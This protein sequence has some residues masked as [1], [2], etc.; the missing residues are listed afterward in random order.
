MKSKKI[1][2]MQLPENVENISVACSAARESARV[3]G[4]SPKDVQTFCL[5]VEEALTN[6]IEMGFG[7]ADDEVDITFYTITSGIGVKIRSFCL[8]LEPEKLPQYNSQRV[9]KYNDTTGLSYHLVKNMSDNFRVYVGEDGARELYFEKY[10]PEQKVQ[11]TGARKK[12]LRVN[13]EHIKRFAVPED[14]ENISRLVLRSH[15]AVLF[16]ESIYYPDMVRE[17]LAEKKMVSVVSEAE[18]GELIAH[19]ALLKD[20]SGDRVEEL[21]YVVSDKNYK[22]RDAAKLP[23]I[24]VED[25]KCR[26]VYA[27]NS[28][29]VTNHVY[30]QKGC[31]ADG[32][33]ENALYLALNTASRHTQNE[34]SESHR[35]GTLGF[36]RYLGEMSPAP[37]FLPPRHREMILDIYANMAIEPPVAEGTAG[38]GSMGG[39]SHIVTDVGFTEGW[40][41]IV[42]KE[43]GPDT[44]SHLKSEVYKAVVQGIPSIQLGLPLSNSMTLEMCSEFESMGFF[45]A[46]VSSG[47]NC[48]ENL[49][50][51]YLNGV[52]P[53]FESVHTF[54]DFAKK[55]KE[56]VAGCWEDRAV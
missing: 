22:S 9:S 39:S 8:P 24:L 56:Y 30:A 26:G 23:A 7:G 41:L 27:I 35:I 10:I 28:Y 36:V 31:L 47:Y 29:V 55:L 20:I 49:M 13:T 25:A 2:G 3:R 6:S 11:D 44:L 53:G 46:G 54:S 45:F 37:L 34:E 38:S 1:F 18:C 21:T 17:M 52:E 5:V 51:Q 40:M 12:V 48:S 4:F 32:F 42:V 33:S 43:Y 50:L 19:F 14:A 15:D 16:G